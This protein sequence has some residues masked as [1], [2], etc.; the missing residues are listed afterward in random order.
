MMETTSNTSLFPNSQLKDSN[1]AKQ[2]SSFQPRSGNT[3][4]STRLNAHVV[5][6]LS[7]LVLS[8]N[9]RP[10]NAPAQG[11]HDSSHG[12]GL[13]ATS[14]FGGARP[15]VGKGG[16]GTHLAESILK[17]LHINPSAISQ[18]LEPLVAGDADTTLIPDDLSVT[19]TSSNESPDSIDANL[20]ELVEAGSNHRNESPLLDNSRNQPET[21]HLFEKLLAQHP[22]LGFAL[23]MADL[24]HKMK[25]LFVDIA[26]LE[27]EDRGLRFGNT[28]NND[29]LL[30]QAE[31]VSNSLGVG[32]ESALGLQLTAE[33]HDVI[34]QKEA[35]SDHSQSDDPPLFEM[36]DPLSEQEISMPGAFNPT[37]SDENSTKEQHEAPY[38]TLNPLVNPYAA[39]SL[40]AVV[41]TLFVVGL[42]VARHYYLSTSTDDLP[43]LEQGVP[44]TDSNQGSQ[45]DTEEKIQVSDSASSSLSEEF[46]EKVSLDPS[47]E[48]PGAPEEETAEQT[49]E[50]KEAKE[51]LDTL[52]D[53]ANAAYQSSRLS[54][55]DRKSTTPIGTPRSVTNALDA[56]RMEMEKDRTAFDSVKG[57]LTRKLL[58]ARSRPATPFGVPSRP[59][60]PIT[61]VTPADDSSEF[62]TEKVAPIPMNSRLAI[63]RM[64]DSPRSTSS[65]VS[66]AS[67][68]ANQPSPQPRLG[69][70]PTGSMVLLNSPTPS[71][72]HLPIERPVTA[73]PSVAYMSA[74]ESPSSSFVASD[75]SPIVPFARRDIR[76][77]DEPVSTFGS[78]TFPPT[79]PMP[80]G[81]VLFND[82]SS[83]P[84][85]QIQLRGQQG[86]AMIPTAQLTETALNLA[87]MLPT[88]EWIFQFL[89]VFIGW[90]GFLM[91]PVPRGTASHRRR[92]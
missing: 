53:V 42:V 17:L 7:L 16:F 8:A 55:D 83:D 41:A 37:S 81:L 70:S 84:D 71:M 66:A 10:L 46:N 14:F 26:I 5:L 20:S 85:E 65:F 34:D 87:L 62:T 72:V 30:S 68:L 13:S 44:P 19:R 49:S 88:T 6:G 4:T 78:P 67:T 9:A 38:P 89:V 69:V 27:G 12:L 28:R 73:S 74:E 75:H 57:S 91:R 59:Q 29:V 63:A 56:I 21:L 3:S 50:E 33:E 79:L 61:M 54:L 43:D 35:P 90:F 92:Y 60:T 15:E 77:F 31:G 86:P 40:S 1:I 39:L 47:V 45:G 2:T 24:M 23:G 76:S 18:T 51:A 82:E 64:W 58:L 36:D 11:E 52:I 25:E 22:G 48:T 32:E 80:G